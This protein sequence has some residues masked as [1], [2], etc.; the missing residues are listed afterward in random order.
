MLNQ[1]HIYESGSI[2]APCD[3]C[4]R[5][6]PIRH[7]TSNIR[8]N[9]TKFN[10][11]NEGSQLTNFKAELHAAALGKSAPFNA[12]AT[13]FEKDRNRCQDMVRCLCIKTSSRSG[14]KPSY[15]R[16]ALGLRFFFNF[17]YK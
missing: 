14:F 15:R 13:Y 8:K 12:L 10:I 1:L 9:G 5:G 11:F 6:N 4:R 7:H 2:I 16:S 3:S 17:I